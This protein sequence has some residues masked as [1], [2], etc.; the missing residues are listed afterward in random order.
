MSYAF[1]GRPVMSNF[2]CFSLSGAIAVLQD[3]SSFFTLIDQPAMPTSD[4]SL[5]F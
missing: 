4:G 5:S 2:A 3:F 1:G